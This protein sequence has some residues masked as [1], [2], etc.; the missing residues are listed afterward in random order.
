MDKKEIIRRSISIPKDLDEIISIVVKKYSYKVK[1]ELLF[2]I[3]NQLING[4][5]FIKI[6]YY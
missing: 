5:L 2:N 1:N 4:L 3:T 6:M